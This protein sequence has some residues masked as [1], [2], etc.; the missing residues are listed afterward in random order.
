MLCAKQ[1]LATS[2]EQNGPT[3]DQGLDFSTS[4]G[5]PLHAENVGYQMDLGVKILIAY[6][7]G[8]Q[9]STVVTFDISFCGLF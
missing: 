6:F 1:I 7:I 3:P 4:V 2:A 5:H 8:K 9:T